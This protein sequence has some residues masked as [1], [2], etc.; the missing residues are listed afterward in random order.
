MQLL[1]L[2]AAVLPRCPQGSGSYRGCWRGGE[3]ALPYDIAHC[4][5]FV[6]VL[7][8]AERDVRS[9]PATLGQA[10]PQWFPFQRALPALLALPGEEEPGARTAHALGRGQTGRAA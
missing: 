8:P 9:T 1:V 5:V 2:D 3:A 6:P 7:L 10:G 4:L